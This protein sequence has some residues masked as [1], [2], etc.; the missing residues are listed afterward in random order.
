[1]LYFSAFLQCIKRL[2][3]CQS[4]GISKEDCPNVELCV[5][6]PISAEEDDD[7]RDQSGGSIRPPASYLP[8]ASVGPQQK[9]PQISGI[10]PPPPNSNGHGRPVGTFSEEE[11]IKITTTKRPA[12]VMGA[13]PTNRKIILVI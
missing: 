6:Q 13:R 5:Q 9:P 3:N 8:P 7:L 4:A 10:L 2:Y 1:M 12:M 11:L